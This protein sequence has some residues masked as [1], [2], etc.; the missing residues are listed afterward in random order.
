MLFTVNRQY[1]FNRYITVTDDILYYNYTNGLING[2][3]LLLSLLSILYIIL[4]LIGY[5]LHITYVELF[6]DDIHE[7]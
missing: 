6:E 7:E 1:E 5:R 4:G 2:V 3:L